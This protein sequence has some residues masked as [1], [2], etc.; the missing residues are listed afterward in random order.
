MGLS[1]CHELTEEDDLSTTGGFLSQGAHGLTG[2]RLQSYE[3][4]QMTV[5][6]KSTTVECRLLKCSGSEPEVVRGALW[7]E[8]SW[9]SCSLGGRPAC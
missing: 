5:K 8:Q 4:T 3:T 6:I 7:S 9:G 1:S 2:R